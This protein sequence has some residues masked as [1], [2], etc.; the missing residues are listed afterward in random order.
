MENYSDKPLIGLVT[1]T[2]NSAE[3]LEGFFSSLSVQSLQNYRL[4]VVDNDSED[5]SVN[6]VKDLSAEDPRVVVF[7]NKDNVGVAVGNNQGIRAALD[8][9]CEYIL[10]INNDVEFSS[11][12]LSNLVYQ[13]RALDADML[14]PKMK[15][16]EPKTHIWC[17]GGKFV[18]GRAYGIKHF[19]ELE[20][21]KGQYNE[22]KKIDYAPTCCMLISAGV[23]K[24]IGM[25][26]ENYFVYFDDVD[27]CYRAMKNEVH[28]W[29]T[30]EP[31]LYHKVGSLTG[32]LSDFTIR[33]STLG[34]IYF[35]RKHLRITKGFWIAIYKVVGFI[36]FKTRRFTASNYQ[37]F[38]VGLSAGRRIS[39]K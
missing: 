35:I 37:A 5:A 20:E 36:K 1:V 34:K 4:F 13:I 21:D 26:D 3:V 33:N 23:F 30:P 6:L 22:A 7:A 8:I 15:Y 18:P 31:V 12:L 2:Y 27:F 25:M 9:G 39:L 10:L 29:Y 32:G 11:D 17:A 14:V 38:L 28:L 19:G 16:F 24:K